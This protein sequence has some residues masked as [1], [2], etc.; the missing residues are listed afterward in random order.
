[1]L[2][3]ATSSRPALGPVLSLLALGALCQPD[4]AAAEGL[5]YSLGLYGVATSSPFDADKVKGTAAPDFRIEGES[6]SFGTNGLTYD[7]VETGQFTLSARLAPRFVVADPA[8]VAGLEHLKRDIAVEAGF[9]ASLALGSTE[10]S[11]EALKDVSD[12]HDGMA[13]TAMVGTTFECTD[14]LSIHAQAGATWMDRKLA[15]YSYGVLSSEARPGLAAYS[16]KEALIPTVGVTAN[17]ALTDKTALVGGLT[18]DFLPDS[19]TASPIVKRD[20]VV[21]VMLGLRHDF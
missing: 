9:A 12:T 15:T 2:H 14:R 3:L 18:A 4:G 10:L 20:N 5:K 19:V 21:S 8:D 13:V 11:L 7:L 17:Y 16:V 1:M 6:F